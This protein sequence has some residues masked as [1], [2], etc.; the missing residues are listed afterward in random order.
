MFS[1]MSLMYLILTRKHGCGS[2]ATALAPDT[3]RRADSPVFFF[4]FRFLIRADL[5]QFTPKS[6]EIHVK[7]KI[8]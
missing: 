8:K 2:K 4:F 3:W 1:T 7:N 6:A 5:G